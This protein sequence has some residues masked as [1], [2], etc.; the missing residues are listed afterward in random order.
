VSL[1]ID[2]FELDHLRANAFNNL[3][4]VAER[5]GDS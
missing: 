1:R 4:L 3:V 5:V 2:D